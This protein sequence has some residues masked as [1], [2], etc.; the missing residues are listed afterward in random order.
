MLALIAGII[1][2]N[3]TGHNAA[4]AL[5][6]ILLIAAAIVGA[7]RRRQTAALL[8]AFAAV[9]FLAV[10]VAY[11]PPPQSL[12]QSP[13]KARVTAVSEAAGGRMVTAEI[14]GRLRANI[15]VTSFL[16]TIVE[17]DSILLSNAKFKS[18]ESRAT[19]PDEVDYADIYRRRHISATATVNHTDI[20]VIGH[21]RSLMQRIR[22]LRPRALNLLLSANISDDTGSLLAAMLLADTSM[23]TDDLRANYSSAG[24][25][26]LLALSGLHVGIIAAIIAA[27]LWPLYVGRHNRSRYAVTI[28]ALW[29]F[30]IAT[31]LTP[32]VT[33]AVIMTMVFMV[34]RILQRRSTPINS[35]CFAAILILI[36]SPES[37]TDI[38][39][40]LSFAAVAGIIVF[41]PAIN[42]VDHRRR[43]W[44]YRAVGMVA[45]PLSAMS[46]S[47]VISAYYFHSLPLLFI[48]ANVVTTWL[49]APLI[50]G[51]ALLILLQALGIPDGALCHLL[52]AITAVCNTVAEQTASM[53]NAVV[54]N[55]YFSPWWFTA[56]GAV[57]LLLAVAR[58][59]RRLAPLMAALMVAAATAGAMWLLAPQ[60]PPTEH[61][62]ALHKDSTDILIRSGD[63]A[64]LYTSASTSA[65]RS[66]AL[67]RARLLY[68]HYLAKRSLP[69]LT[70]LPDSIDAPG[71]S[72]HGRRL[73]LAGVSYGVIND[74]APDVSAERVD[75][76]LVCRG[77]TADVVSLVQ[78]RQPKRATVICT[79]LNVRRRRRYLRE[80]QEAGITAVLTQPFSVDSVA[81][82]AN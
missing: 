74:N 39:F 65:Q 37:L 70:L 28:L 53:P 68:P 42:C 18:P 81:T 49:A 31:G 50:A 8:C 82:P 38:S 47:G 16:P 27:M 55:V 24:M 69:E 52:D 33:R 46:L 1:G 19:V 7:W 57:A 3:L 29:I 22:D 32:S 23:L 15:Y 5:V 71:V 58:Y 6:P 54:R 12:P 78:A 44:L 4:V 60:Y 10:D 56:F 13:V 67:E 26:H 51:G 20:C 36:F 64:Y 61:F 11:T 77:F 66:E 45:L 25:A 40:Q 63:R 48:P 17:G 2:A 9:G 14:G 80:L 62:F 34:G 21:S 30:A 75:Y 35:L 76:L 73:V 41:Y 72:L 59:L 79:S 43:P